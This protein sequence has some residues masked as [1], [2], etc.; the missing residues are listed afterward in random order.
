MNNV[1]SVLAKLRAIAAMASRLPAMLPAATASPAPVAAIL[2]QDGRLH[3]VS[4]K[5]VN[6]N[7]ISMFSR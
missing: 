6:Y 5:F 7:G 1:R 4:A 3:R 2:R